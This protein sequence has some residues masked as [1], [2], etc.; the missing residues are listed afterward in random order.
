M[1][2][3][4]LGEHKTKNPSR[5]PMRKIHI[6]VLILVAIMGCST[7]GR[8]MSESEPSITSLGGAQYAITYYAQSLP[9]AASKLKV[10]A[11]EA[12]KGRSYAT[13]EYKVDDWRPIYVA[14]QARITCK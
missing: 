8:K 13:E 4:Q 7:V 6:I 1:K 3:Y 9:D 2:K 10:I 14:V 11:S 5:H 12:C